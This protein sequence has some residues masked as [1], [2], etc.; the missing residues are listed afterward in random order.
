[1]KKLICTLRAVTDEETLS[2]IRILPL[3]EVSSEKGDFVVDEES[4]EAI[5]KTISRRGIDVVIDYEHQ[6]LD[7]VQAPAAGWIKDIILKEDGI[8]AEVE[9]TEKATAY[10]KN[11]EYRYLSP[12]IM[13]RKNDRKAVELHSVALTNTPAINEMQP[14]INKLE[15]E[16]FM[17]L[18]KL[19]ALL[20]LGENATE[21]EIEAAIKTLKEKESDDEVVANK[22]ILGLLS[23]DE[24]AKTEDVASAI[25]SLKNTEA[26]KELNALKAQM[27]EQ[28]AERLVEKALKSGKITP[29]QKGWAKDYALKDTIGFEAFLEKAPQIV[30]FG[31]TEILANSKKT[32]MTEEAKA[33]YAQLGIAA[34]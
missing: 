11:K 8:W 1:M 27:A 33:V 12:V 21:A 13:V 2:P 15:K 26:E 6:T 23:L 20:G 5:K 17:E 32:E 19:A 29:A 14:I 31:E 30:P 10:L 7:N 9:W 3:G 34:Q 25:L 18:A 28:N 16:N 22:T 4:F 24:T